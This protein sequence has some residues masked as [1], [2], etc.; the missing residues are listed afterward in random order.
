MIHDFDPV[1]EKSQ[2]CIAPSA[3]QESKLQ[4]SF[5]Y[6]CKIGARVVFRLTRGGIAKRKW[7][8]V[9]NGHLT[10]DFIFSFGDN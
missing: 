6:R 3:F 4:I 10:R 1:V 2:M 8:F 7:T 9:F 5:W